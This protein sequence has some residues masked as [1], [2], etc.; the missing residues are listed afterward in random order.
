MIGV[1]GQYVVSISLEGN[2]DFVDTEQT[3]DEQG[4]VKEY[5]A[6]KK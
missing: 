1:D 5:G 3:Y 4:S 2:E 6:V